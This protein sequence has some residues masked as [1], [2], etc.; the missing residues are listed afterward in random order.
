MLLFIFV[1]SDMITGWMDGWMDG[2]I[3]MMFFFFI[4]SFKN[5][6]SLHKIT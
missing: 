1:Y 6:R 5:T 3:T 4:M 2:W